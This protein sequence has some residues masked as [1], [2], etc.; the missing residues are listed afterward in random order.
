M[1]QQMGVVGPKAY[2]KAYSEWLKAFDKNPEDY[3]AVPDFIE[4]PLTLYQEIQF[5]GQGRDASDEP[6]G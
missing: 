1:A 4:K 3:I 2:Y 5:C 6:A